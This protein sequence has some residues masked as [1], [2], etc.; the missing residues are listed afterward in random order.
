MGSV[1]E[2]VFAIALMVEILTNF[3]KTVLPRLEKEYIPII[4]GAVGIIVAVTT[5]TG[6]LATLDIP[7]SFDIIDFVITGVIVSRGANIVHDIAKKL[8]F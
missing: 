5:Q 1:F 7:V 2:K 6:M 4:A 8:N 3:I